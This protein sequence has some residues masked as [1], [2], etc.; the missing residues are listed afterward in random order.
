MRLTL[1]TVVGAG[2]LGLAGVVWSCGGSSVTESPP[3]PLA[4][5][6]VVV[7]LEGAAE[8]GVAVRL[9]QAGGS[10]ALASRTTDGEGR[11]VFSQL[12]SGSYE[13][14]VDVPVG[15]ELSQGAARRQV[16]AAVGSTATVTFQLVAEEEPEGVV[17][18]RVRQNLTFDPADVTI[19]RGQT[20][21]WASEDA[22]LH[23]VTPDG[24]SEWSE[25]S[26]GQ[27]GARFEHTF[28]SA[29]DFP[30]FCAPHQSA[31]MTGVIRVQ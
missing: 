2:V 5:I 19:E 18:V 17:V 28:S 7:T 24:H 23:T 15:A 25:A 16:V 3:D 29:G 22:M 1:R 11:A 12:A 14:E 26:L 6:V 27:V 30:Y 31:G 8:P 10:D 9:Y 13:V 4:E 20:I 21:R